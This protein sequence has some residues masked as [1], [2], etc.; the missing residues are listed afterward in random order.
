MKRAGLILFGLIVVLTSQNALGQSIVE[1]SGEAIETERQKDFKQR[2]K[3]N[4]LG[5]L[6]RGGMIDH[7]RNNVFRQ[8]ALTSEEKEEIERIRTLVA[9]D[10]EDLERHKIFLAQPGTGLFRLIPDFGCGSKFTIKID[11]NCLNLAPGTSTYSFRRRDHAADLKYFDIQLEGDNL[12]SKGFLTQGILTK[13]GDVPLETISLASSRAAAAG[14]ALKLLV[15]FKPEKDIQRVRNQYR[16]IAAG[17]EINGHF[18]SNSIKAEPNQTYAYRVVAY[19]KSIITVNRFFLNIDDERFATL[20]NDKR[21]DLTIAFRVIRRDSDG[22]IT[23]VW[24][25]LARRDSPDLVFPR[26]ETFSDFRPKTTAPVKSTLLKSEGKL[27][28]N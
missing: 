9:P 23:I 19:R 2:E 16:Q 10:P 8:R 27:I 5:G 18:Y 28:N 11:E 25:E 17:M 3:R 1:G 22:R 6:T 4:N 7:P 20:R 14:G 13:L 15:D 26:N 24:K 12:V 21:K